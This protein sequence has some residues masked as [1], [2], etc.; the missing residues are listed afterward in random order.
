MIYAA[1]FACGLA[2]GVG[3]MASLVILVWFREPDTEELRG[4]DLER[5]IAN[6]GDK[7]SVQS[8]RR[9]APERE[10]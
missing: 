8:S 1:V 2:V 7:S 4:E 3:G 10:P 9:P 5:A 6:L